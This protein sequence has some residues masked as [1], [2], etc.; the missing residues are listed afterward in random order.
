MMLKAWGKGYGA[1]GN[2]VEQL[3]FG[4]VRQAHHERSAQVCEKI[5]FSPDGSIYVLVIWFLQT[6]LS[7]PAGFEVY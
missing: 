4:I 2:N 6:G 3:N 7:G 5:V 1:K